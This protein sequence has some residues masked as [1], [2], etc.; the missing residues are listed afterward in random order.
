M[1]RIIS[2]TAL[3]IIILIF[4]N[5][6]YAKVNYRGFI[7]LA[8]GVG[9]TNMTATT[10]HGLQLSSKFFLGLGVGTN[11]SKVYEGWSDLY[12]N[13]ERAHIIENKARIQGFL[14][15]RMDFPIS[16]RM[17]FFVNLDPGYSFLTDHSGVYIFGGVGL[18]YALSKSV[19]LNF[20][21]TAGS[22]INGYKYREIKYDYSEYWGWET[23]GTSNDKSNI[24]VGIN[25]GIDF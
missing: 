18:R 20:G 19:G 17:R 14:R 23:Y 21:L 3:A 10:T 2:I 16:R 12:S 24:M 5:G 7:D 8:G 9:S 6:L 1:K 25:V 13:G 4:S 15:A 11:I 22:I